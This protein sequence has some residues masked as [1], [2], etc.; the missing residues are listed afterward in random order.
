LATH[1]AIVAMP[2][3]EPFGAVLQLGPTVV[4]PHVPFFTTAGGGGGGAGAG[5]LS[6]SDVNAM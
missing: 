1:A 6:T 3:N 2:G 4:A 5:I